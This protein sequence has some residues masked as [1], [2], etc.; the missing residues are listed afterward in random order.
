MLVC[1]LL[2]A[3]AWEM[4]IDEVSFTSVSSQCQIVGHNTGFSRSVV[5]IP[6]LICSIGHQLAERH[7]QCLYVLG[8]VGCDGSHPRDVML[9]PQLPE[10]GFGELAA[11]IQH[12]WAVQP[13]AGF[14]NER[15]S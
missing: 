8:Q 5:L 9:C 6:L 15:L 4:K 2:T 1:S 3:F 13:K 14:T 10:E 12:R 11:A 7:R